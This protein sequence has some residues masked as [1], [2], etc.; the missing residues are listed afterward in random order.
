MEKQLKNCCTKEDMSTMT[1]EIRQEVRTNSQRIDKLFDMHKEDSITLTRKVESI[2]N[3]HIANKKGILS[4][5]ETE[6]SNQRAFLLNR[7]SVRLWPIP[8][9]LELVEQVR[10][11]F[12]TVLSVPEDV[13]KSIKVEDV[14]RIVQPRRSLITGEVVVRFKSAQ[15]RDVIQSYAVNLAGIDGKAGL[16]LDVPDHLR[17]IFRSF[18][19]HAAILKKKFGSVKRSIKFDDEQQSFCMDIKLPNT[20]WHHINQEEVRQAAR[21]GHPAGA[22]TMDKNE[23]EILQEKKLILLQTEEEPVVVASDG[24]EETE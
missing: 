5:T 11:F 1:K 14:Q 23:Q 2:V 21:K 15:D 22:I 10:T 3:K 13:A 4:L 24:E 12:Y 18:E 7:R 9:G 17:G 6:D 16:R 19:A 20:R 8:K